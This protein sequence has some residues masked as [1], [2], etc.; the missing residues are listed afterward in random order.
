LTKPTG[1]HFVLHARALHGNPYNGHSLAATV[2]DVAAM[3]GAD[4]KRTHVDNGYRGHNHP[5]RFQVW[6][7][8]Q[9]RRTTAA[10]KREM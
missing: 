9:I 6:I 10:H 8:D 5:N 1:D 3:T 4:V 2:A 7:S